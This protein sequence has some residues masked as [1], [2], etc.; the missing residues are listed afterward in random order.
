MDTI[1]ACIDG[2]SNSTAVVDAAIWAAQRLQA[3]LS[4]LHVLEP[5]PERAA[6]SDYSGAIG[7]GAHEALLHELGQLDA[8]RAQL[9]QEEG[10]Q[11]L[12]AAR[13]RATAAGLER[14]D[15]RLRH[16]ELVDSLLDLQPELRLVLM[17][18]HFH[19]QGARRLHLDHRVERV[20]RQLERPVLVLPGAAFVAPQRALLAFDG[21]AS[22][23]R[24]VTK[25]ATSPL[26]KGLPI[27]LIWVGG[28][29]HLA[30][31][32][33]GEALA[34]LQAAGFVASAEWH[35]GEPEQVLPALLNA[36]PERLLV[37][38]AH[39]H[40]RLRQLVLGS[41]TATLLRSVQV[42]V[43]VLR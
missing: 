33:L 38:G 10:R 27:G 42:P 32:A 18:E 24:C 29:E 1:F 12:A 35:A 39:G 43:L 3:P 36:Q 2:R 9:E 20:L 37:M 31:H 19:H 15:A 4:F 22:A 28:D 34:P 40:S 13:A 7:L 6:V 23:R 30:H 17:G 5:H 41:T 11:L 26:L 16:G 21:S 8:R 14:H 25:L